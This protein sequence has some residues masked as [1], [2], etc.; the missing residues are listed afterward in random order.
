M[1]VL[2]DTAEKVKTSEV[3]RPKALLKTSYISCLI[4]FVK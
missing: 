3:D 2:L 4:I 1:T